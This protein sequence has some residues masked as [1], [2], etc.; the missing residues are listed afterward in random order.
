MSIDQPALAWRLAHFMER[1]ARCIDND[2][3]EAWPSFFDERCTYKVTTRDNLAQGYPFGLIYADSRGMLED[4]VKS[5]REANVYEGQRYRHLLGLPFVTGE[6]GEGI[7][8]ETSFLVMRI[9]R[10]G[11]TS[12]F[13]TGCYRDR[14]LGVGELLSLT[15]RLVVCDSCRVDTLLAIPL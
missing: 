12:T 6:D 4:R 10:D 5:L 7:R 8:V 3:L 11:A 9:M 13:A 15:E 2:E 14:F 1:Y